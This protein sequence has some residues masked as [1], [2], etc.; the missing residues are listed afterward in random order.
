V[1]FA[2]H[3]AAVLAL[4]GAIVALGLAWGHASSAGQAGFVFYGREGSGP[5]LRLSDSGD[6]IR[7]V[8]LEAVIMTV[9][10]AAS[11]VRRQR[12]RALRTRRTVSGPAE[13]S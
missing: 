1:R 6:L 2:R 5:G 8:E 3:L 11:A 10:I 13:D 9:V 12:R 7:T 4:V